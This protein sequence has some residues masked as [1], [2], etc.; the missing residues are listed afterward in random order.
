MD[1][2]QCFAKLPS[3]DIALQIAIYYYSVQIASDLRCFGDSDGE[4]LARMYRTSPGSLTAAVLTYISR[5]LSDRTQMSANVHQMSLRLMHYNARLIEFTQAQALRRLD[6]GQL[7][8]NN[9]N[10]YI[11]NNPV[12]VYIFLLP[13]IKSWIKIRLMFIV[14][15]VCLSVRVL[16]VD[17]SGHA[18]TMHRRVADVLEAPVWYLASAVQVTVYGVLEPTLRNNSPS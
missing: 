12:N 5:A 1:A 13:Q 8:S 17:M 15:Y 7:P 10:L 16:T 18:S 2:E 3:T 11:S 6:R 4:G 9:S 14:W